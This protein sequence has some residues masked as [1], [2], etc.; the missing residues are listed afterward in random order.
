MLQQIAVMGGWDEDGT[1][2]GSIEL[3]SDVMIDNWRRAMMLLGTASAA[4]MLDPQLPVNDVLYRLFHEEG[5]R[6]FPPTP[7]IAKCRC[8]RK[9]IAPIIDPLP[10][11]EK[12]ELAENGQITVTCEFCNKNYYFPVESSDHQPN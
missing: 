7:I 6:V 4:E 8:S 12:R 5:V 9:K 1:E 2:I 3:P 11:E 10:I